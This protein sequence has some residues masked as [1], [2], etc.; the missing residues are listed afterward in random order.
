MALMVPKS[1]SSLL[2]VCEHRALG[3]VGVDVILAPQKLELKQKEEHA[4]WAQ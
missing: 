3:D 1:V 2:T 4:R